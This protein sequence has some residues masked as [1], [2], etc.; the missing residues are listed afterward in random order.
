MH[1]RACRRIGGGDELEH[2][3]R[4]AAWLHERRIKELAPTETCARRRC[5]ASTTDLERNRGWIGEL[6]RLKEPEA[7]PRCVDLKVDEGSGR[8]RRREQSCVNPAGEGRRIR[9]AG[10][11]SLGSVEC[12]VHSQDEMAAKFPAPIPSSAS[13]STDAAGAAEPRDSSRSKATATSATQL[14]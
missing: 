6:R 7:P 12:R 9:E 1:R 5:A 11:R 8:R 4:R 3:P 2:S 14:A 10:E 13:T